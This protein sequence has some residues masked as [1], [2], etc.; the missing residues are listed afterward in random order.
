ML[1]QLSELLLCLNTRYMWV[2]HRYVVRTPGNVDLKYPSDKSVM[3]TEAII[4]FS[5]TF[6]RVCQ[7]N[8]PACTNRIIRHVK[9][10]CDAPIENNSRSFTSALKPLEKTTN[11][12]SNSVV[13]SVLLTIALCKFFRMVWTEVTVNSVNIIIIELT[14]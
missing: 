12:I 7:M 11:P 4:L 2:I 10:N 6:R 14:K 3:Q 9:E 8:Q 1:L 5:K 13:K